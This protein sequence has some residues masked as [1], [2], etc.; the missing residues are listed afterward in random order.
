MS[1]SAQ[2]VPPSSPNIP[3]LSCNTTCFLS[4]REC[5]RLSH[6]I[7]ATSPL[8]HDSTQDVSPPTHLPTITH[9]HPTCLLAIR[10]M[11]HRS[12]NISIFHTSFPSSN[13]C[14]YLR[15]PSFSAQHSTH[16]SQRVTSH[17]KISLLPPNMSHLSLDVR[18]FPIFPTPTHTL[19]LYSSNM[20]P[21]A[22]PA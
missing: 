5:L 2:D 11:F 3:L 17:P 16:H 6:A 10:I 21:C 9:R 4:R 1:D 7:Y 20:S 15:Y 19:R 22:P 8:M 13:V 14:S 18:P 12:P